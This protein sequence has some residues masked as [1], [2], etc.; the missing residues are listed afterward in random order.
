M[1]LQGC[2]YKEIARELGMESDDTPREH[3]INVRKKLGVGSSRYE[4][5]KRCQE[6]GLIK[7][8]FCF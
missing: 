8:E 3:I 1:Y 6:L 2:T 5:H 7:I 4:M